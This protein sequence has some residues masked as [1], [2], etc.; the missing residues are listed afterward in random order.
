MSDKV[1]ALTLAQ[2]HMSGMIMAL[3]P[4]KLRSMADLSHPDNNAEE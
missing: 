3:V 4:E 2:A 1:N